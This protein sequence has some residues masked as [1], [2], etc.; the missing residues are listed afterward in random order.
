M[1]KRFENGH[2]FL[3]RPGLPSL[4]FLLVNRGPLCFFPALMIP[5]A[6]KASCSSISFFLACVRRWRLMS[7]TTA[8]QPG[9]LHLTCAWCD[10]GAVPS[11]LDDSDS[12]PI[13]SS[14]SSSDSLNSSSSSST[15]VFFNRDP[16]DCFCCLFFPLVVL[17]SSSMSSCKVSLTVSF[18]LH[19]FQS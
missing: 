12:S 10:L 14:S 13:S 1:K 3:K 16:S 2:H 4:L 15:F 9:T 7:P 18:M 11:S 6:F 17:P 19:S 8:L 5:A